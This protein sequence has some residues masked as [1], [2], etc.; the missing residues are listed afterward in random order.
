MSDTPALTTTDLSVRFGSTDALRAV[1]ASVPA[2]TITGLLGRNGA[3][4][5]TLLR[6]LAGREPRFSGSAAVF[7]LDASRL[8]GAPGL[9]HL[10]TQ[11][12]PSTGDRSLAALARALGRVRPHFDADRY[13][14]L[15]GQFGVPARARLRRLSSGQETAA[16]A[17]LALASRSPLTL[18][19]EPQ[20]GLDAPSRALLNRLIVEEQGDHPRTWVIST[21]LIDETAP[22]FERV[23]VLDGGR[24]V[25]DEAVDALLDRYVRLEAGVATIESLPHVGGLDRLGDRASA[26]VPADA[27]PAGLAS[28]AHP[29][30]LQELAGVLPITAKE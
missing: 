27:V 14:D 1:S 23:L 17:S 7:G 19:D 3:G 26:I 29:L 22:L 4:K 8:G 28:R 2:G 24:L 9:V 10:A 13:H 25:T 30:T 18:L 12:W 20:T 21:H 11:A 15:L 5:T 6:V 16:M